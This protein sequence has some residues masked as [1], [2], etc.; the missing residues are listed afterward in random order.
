[1]GSPITI[2]LDPLMKVGAA[3]LPYADFSWD[4]VGIKT[5]WPD[6]E[7][8]S[9]MLTVGLEDVLPSRTGLLPESAGRSLG[10]RNWLNAPARW[11]TNPLASSTELRTTANLRNELGCFMAAT[12]TSWVLT[13]GEHPEFARLYHGCPFPLVTRW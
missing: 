9:I 5:M 2:D 1:M 7:V 10:C 3:C 11:R 8:P 4:V 6:L 12:S 13:Q